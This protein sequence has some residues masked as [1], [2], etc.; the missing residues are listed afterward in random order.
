MQAQMVVKAR[1]EQ[2]QT[3]WIL[4]LRLYGEVVYAVDQSTCKPPFQMA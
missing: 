1:M 2:I 3:E 4:S